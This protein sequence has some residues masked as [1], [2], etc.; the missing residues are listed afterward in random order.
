M[1]RKFELTL[2]GEERMGFENRVP[3][4]LEEW[5]DRRSEKCIK[6]RFI[7]CCLYII[8]STDRRIHKQF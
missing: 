5:N 3:R 7:I 2:R 1:W 8:N 4:T 6:A